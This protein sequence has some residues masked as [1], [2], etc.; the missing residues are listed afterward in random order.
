MK[1]FIC[2]FFTTSILVSTTIS[3]FA[4]KPVADLLL[5]NVSVIDVKKAKTIALSGKFIMP[6]LWDMHVHFG[7]DTLVE[8]NKNPLLDITHT[9]S[10]A[11]LIRRSVYL[12]QAELDQLLVLATQQV[13]DGE[14]K[15]Q[16]K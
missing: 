15:E 14:Q 4:Q 11:G 16:L 12:S 1:G 13:S 3:S 7:G 6:S 8:E 2:C 10:T 5:H 9:R